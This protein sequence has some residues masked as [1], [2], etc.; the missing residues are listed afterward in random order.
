VVPEVVG[1]RPIVRPIFMRK[2]F[3]KFFAWYEKYT[4]QNTLIAAS[5]FVTQILHLVWL[6]LF[7]I[8]GR[9]T[10][11]P[12]WEPSDFWESLL[13]FFDYFEIPAII[14][15]TL[16]YLNK[17][18]KNENF[19]KSLRNLVF[20]NTQWLH[21]FWITDE[22]VIDKFTGASQYSTILPVWLAW[23]AIMIDYLELPVIY[24]TAKESLKIVRKRMIKNSGKSR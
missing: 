1:S 11:E 22:F 18:R 5:L 2:A 19:K 8:A 21:I 3:T 10:G 7:V 9:L 20:I 12:L 24:D 14:A 6:A 13:I 4:E 17:L 23:V 15:T 16:F